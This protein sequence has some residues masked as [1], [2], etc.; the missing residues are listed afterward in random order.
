MQKLNVNFA[1]VTLEGMNNFA[2]AYSVMSLTDD[3]YRTLKARLKE[4]RVSKTDSELIAIQFYSA[5]KIK[6]I[7]RIKTLLTLV[8]MRMQG[9]ESPCLPHI[10]YITSI[11]YT[12]IPRSNCTFTV[13]I[14][15]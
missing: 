1:D 8:N 10:A 6:E 13:T 5:E 2:C 7:R 14:E 15:S 4:L 12:E 3:S 11:E 9:I